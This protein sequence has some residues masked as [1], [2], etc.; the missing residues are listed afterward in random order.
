MEPIAGPDDIVHVPAPWGLKG[1]VYQFA[2]WTPRTQAED[3]PAMAYSPLEANSAFA[4]PEGS[5]PLGGLSV[6]QIIRYTESPVGPY[7]ELLFVPGSHENVVDDEK[8]GKRVTKRNARVTRIYVSQ[9]YTCWNGRTNWNI[10][11]HLAKFEWH[12][13]PSTS[14]ATVKV[15]PHDTPK[16]SGPSSTYDATEATAA[17]VP[18]FQASFKP[19]PFTPSFPF[20]AAV[21]RYLG[22]NPTLVQ[23]PLPEGKDASQKELP[24]TSKWCA[25]DPVQSSWKTKLGWFDLRQQT[26]G[27]GQVIGGAEG[28]N[29]WPGLGRWHLGIRMENATIDFGEGRY[30][31]PSRST[32]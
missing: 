4:S 13:D 12:T 18:F 7:D 3:M 29:F 28:E 17:T 20:S 1:T 23:P 8:T 15:Y 16:A 26:D 25:I 10:P 11:K 19:V 22:L 27:R 31:D 2:W 6:V 30:W 32:M 14:T 9:K 24:G 21:F 5:K